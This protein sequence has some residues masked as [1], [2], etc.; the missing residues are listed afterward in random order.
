MFTGI[1][2]ALGTVTALESLPDGSARITIDAGR[3]IEDLPRGGSLAVNGVCLTA[4]PAPRAESSQKCDETSAERT[5]MTTR[6]GVDGIFTADVMGETL[7]L[8][9][10]GDLAP[11]S[12][13]NLER[14]LSPSGRFDGHIV[15]GHVD[16]TGELVSITD[17]GS[18]AVYRFTVPADLAPFTALKG[19]IAI[20]G[21]SLTI[22]GVSPA[23]GTSAPEDGAAHWV[24]VSLIP[25]TREHT[26]LGEAAPGRRVNLEVDVIAKYAARLTAFATV[27]TA[28]N[29]STEGA[30]A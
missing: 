10:L 12:R 4:V 13:V 27:P 25:A 1:I 6:R 23:P 29:A 24:E 26:I 28:Q 21:V 19:S 5:F 16:G 22:S 18:W 20:D 17:H 7:R 9:S 15:Q 2:E 14:C 11:G 30:T 3:L 8:T